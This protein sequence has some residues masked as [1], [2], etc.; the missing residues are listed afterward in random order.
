MKRQTLQQALTKT[1]MTLATTL[2]M[3]LS[4]AAVTTVAV[5]A[6]AAPYIHTDQPY[7]DEY[8]SDEEAYDASELDSMYEQIYAQAYQDAIDDYE[9]SVLDHIRETNIYYN[10]AMADDY[11]SDYEIN[12]LQAQ[13]NQLYALRDHI[14]NDALE[15]LIEEYEDMLLAALS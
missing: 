3:T 15:N 12:Y 2:A 1:A 5:P 10:N 13:L 6:Q 4:F 11:L 7:Y 8:A 14:D 9:Q